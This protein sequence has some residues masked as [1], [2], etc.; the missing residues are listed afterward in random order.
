MAIVLVPYCSINYTGTPRASKFTELSW[1]ILQLH[2]NA[3]RSVENASSILLRYEW[4]YN[5][6]W[7][8]EHLF[9]HKFSPQFQYHWNQQQNS[10]PNEQA[11]LSNI[12]IINSFCFIQLPFYF[13]LCIYTD[14]SLFIATHH[15]SI[16]ACHKRYNKS[17]TSHDGMFFF[18][19]E[20]SSAL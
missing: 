10:Q 5:V 3:E 19:L 6:S 17:S 12:I 20:L 7:H 13:L 9:Q 16:S 11:T 1:W 2:M 15:L 4:T 18:L 8:V 14:I